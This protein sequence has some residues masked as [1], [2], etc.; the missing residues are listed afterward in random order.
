MCV[1]ESMQEK[2]KSINKSLENAECTE[3]TGDGF[4]NVI[5]LC[6]MSFS[7]FLKKNLS[8]CTLDWDCNNFHDYE[9]KKSLQTQI[10]K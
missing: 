1:Q 9:G 4:V 7:L 10:L 6:K 2:L 5:Y 8:V 3:S